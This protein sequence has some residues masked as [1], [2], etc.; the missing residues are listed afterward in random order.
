MCHKKSKNTVSSLPELWSRIVPADVYLF[1]VNN[2]N[3]E[4]CVKYVQS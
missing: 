3:T 4:K 2:W 1:K